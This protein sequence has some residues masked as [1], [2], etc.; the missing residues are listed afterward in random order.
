MSNEHDESTHNSTAPKANGHDH[1]ANGT[2]V[3]GAVMSQQ[4]APGADVE[5][6]VSETLSGR[7]ILLTGAT[8]FLGKAFLSM[9]LRFHPDIDQVYVLIRPRTNQSAE[10][11]FFQQ[12]AANSVMDPLREIYEDGYLDFI[13]EK[14][15]PLAGD[16][17][18]EHLGLPEKE[19]RA[20]SSNLDLFINSAGLTNFNPNLENALTINTLSQFNMLDFVRLGGH[21]A[22]YMHVS[23]CF[24]A[25]NVD[26]KV[27]EEL[28]TPTRYPNY[29]ELG[30][31][32]HAEREI[33]DCRAMI[34]HAKQLASDQE[35][36]SH[37]AQQAR[38]KLRKKNLDPNNPVLLEQTLSKLRRDWLRN[39]LSNEGRERADFWGWPNIYTYTKSLGERV[40]AA[41]KDEINLAIFRPAVI[42]SAASYP[43]VGW[44][45]GINTSAP[46]AFLM[47]KGHRYVPARSNVNLDVVPV[48]YVAGAMLAVSAALINR[49]QHDVYHC[50]SGHLNPVPVPR[51]IE[52]TNLGLRKVNRTKRMPLWQKAVLNSLDSVPVSKDTFDRRSAPQIKRAAS[53]LR[54]LLDKV[55]TKHL[56]GLGKA[57]KTVQSGLKAAETVTGITEKV[58]ELMVPF[59]HNNAFCFL[60][61]NLPDLVATLPESERTR[62]GS[63]VEDL[64]WRHY[65]IDVHIPG[66]VRHAF[67]ELEAK[68]S[69][70]GKSTYTYDDL[71]E[72]FEA[73]THNYA[74]RVALQH[75]AGGI[76]ERFTY[77]ELKQ[78]AERAADALRALG[79]GDHATVLIVSENRPQWGMTYFGILKAGGVAVPVDPD[80]SAAQLANLMKS[81]RARAAVLSDTVHAR[82]GAELA[83]LLREEGLPAMLLSY[84]QLFNR[85][86]TSD[87]EATDDVE[88]GD[89]AADGGRAG[90]EPSAA[91]VAAA[92]DGEPLASLIYTSGTTGTPKGV[93]LT[94]Q[95]FTHLLAS[96]QQTFDIN[97]RD[98]FL[99]VLPLHHTFE[100]A[101]GFLMPLSKGATIT[102]LDELS[103][104]ELNSA[105]ASTRITALIGVPA[106]WQ[107][108]HRRIKQRLD[109]APTAVTWALDFLMGIN[110]TLRDRFNVN[111]G[112]TAFRAVHS[113]FGGRLRYL[114]SGGA[115]LP[116][117]VLEAFHG[118]GFNLYEGYGL[119]EAA[120][121][122]TVNGPHDGLNPGSVGKALP[123]IEVDIHNPNDQGVGEVIARGRNV[124]RGYLDRPED[125]DRALK[126]GWLFT[127]DLGTIDEH[128]RLSIVGRAKE[129]IVT[130]GG[131]NVYPDELEEVYGASDDIEELS[132]VGLPDGSGS[133]RVACL[134]RP[135]IAE[136]ASDEDAA[137]VR[138][139]IREHFRVE[140]A[141]LASHN[142]I[143]V[144]R[145]VD[146]ELPRTATRKIKRSAVVEILERLQQREA[147]VHDAE[148][149]EDPQWSWLYEQIALL[150]D[151]DVEDVHSGV[152]FADELGFDSLMV[153]ELAS[154][155]AE[156]DFQVSPDHLNAIQTVRHLEELLAGNASDA[157][158]TTTPPVHERVD[159]IDVH[160]ALAEFGK[161]ML[162][163][164]QKKFYDEYFDVE[165]YGR[166]NIPWHDPN[167]IVAANHSSHLDM[168]LV[169]Y[170]LGDFGKDIRA[171]A[172]ADY[173]FSNPARKTYFKNFTNL[174]PVTRS[175]SLE[176]S[177]SGAEEALDHGEMVLLF[178]EGTRSKDGKLQEFRRGLGYLVATK[179]VNVLPLY[180]DGTHR[181]LPKGKA[182]PSLTSRKLKVYIGPMLD[183][184]EL[185]RH[186]DDMTNMDRYDFISQKTR[187][188]I[189]ELR[190][191]AHA[192]PGSDDDDV[193]G[194]FSELN[195]KF[196]RNRLDEEVSFYFSLGNNDNLKWTIIVNADDCQIRTGKPQHGRADCVIKTSP[197]IFK[198]IVTESYVPS[199]DEFMS[200][201]IKTNDPQLLAQFQN[202]FAL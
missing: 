128:G 117:D 96:L 194:L 172:A 201:K 176:A 166:A 21:H 114:I 30:V 35:H 23:T 183:A 164:G 147:A 40:M 44:N 7:R 92:Q 10:E 102:Y 105:M 77:R 140:G 45:E 62:Y 52:L 162:F 188:A 26:G 24:V 155:L 53:G 38:A 178:P 115:A 121:V 118:M 182:V 27:A 151:V 58:F 59:T 20:L 6:S 177:L 50:G 17:T 78:H 159:E 186:S 2:A 84:G 158:V 79:A 70:S 199:M 66:L 157:L 165:I 127:G 80:S 133:E 137:E 57:V 46:L 81:C 185:L 67:P 153:A 13:E 72:L 12:I 189:V 131:K 202:V 106:L 11:R 141:R 95:N 82:V 101:C 129:V 48:D 34:A 32:Y 196:E 51:L 135:L 47:S 191:A 143:N 197:D 91:L 103:G 198:K 149:R 190:D 179:R 31:P 119:T 49:R 126:D 14:C 152:H 36:Q 98:G 175:G 136:G 130:S 3:A 107:L 113:A 93:M 170:A 142:R 89:L 25:G 64:D 55:P 76:S 61:E 122:L 65:W 108:L 74:N 18:E 83:D 132:V 180:I 187:A 169:K 163:R 110:T 4:A 156:R 16:I 112:P 168:G 111:V 120:P 22:S 87:A 160:P 144:L 43:S 1:G 94:H 8:G 97:E 146:E 90:D 150:A 192:R 41:A 181:A 99:S 28:P 15:T 161:K 73:S 37:F 85:A 5:W 60:T 29:D 195:D 39:R 123:G 33:D 139:R 174:I 171:L 68:F 19:A 56:G 125:T 9:L 109:D 100:F 154:I 145:F 69:A 54:G 42:E 134:V 104:E 167:V 138:A 173:F 184:Y 124:M 200:G 71:L 148:D 193:T 88:L 116:S 75:H 86:L 63:P